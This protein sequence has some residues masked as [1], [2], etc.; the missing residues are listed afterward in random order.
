ME[1]RKR[2]LSCMLI[3][4]LTSLFLCSASF[5]ED[6]PRMTKEQVKDL[7]GYHGVLILDAR[8][9]AAWAN[10]DSKIKGAVRVDPSDVDSWAGTLSKDKTIIIYCS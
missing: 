9:G 3:L 10:S 2:I 1:K 5:A 6:A 8:T 4:F 7:L